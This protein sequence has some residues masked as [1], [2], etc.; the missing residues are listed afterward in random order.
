MGLMSHD[1]LV[2][3]KPRK[4]TA[5][6]DFGNASAFRRA[7]LSMMVGCPLLVAPGWLPLKAWSLTNEERS[8][9]REAF[10]QLDLDREFY[11]PGTF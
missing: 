1:L 6:V 5:L 4:V 9:V 2:D 8:K 10:M 3:L 11:V 7:C